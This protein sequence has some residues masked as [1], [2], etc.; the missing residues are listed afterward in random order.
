MQKTGRHRK[1]LTIEY[2]KQKKKKKF[3]KTPKKIPMKNA[4][5]QYNV[6]KTENLPAPFISS[7]NISRRVEE[8]MN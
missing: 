1:G 4:E 5:T 3:R 2:H 8:R 6:K 7:K